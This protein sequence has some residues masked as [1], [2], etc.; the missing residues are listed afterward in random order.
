[1]RIFFLVLSFFIFAHSV[2]AGTANLSWNANTE[3]DLAGYKIYYGASPR[4][5]TCP[6]GGYSSNI[7]VG[8]V[9][10]YALSGL[11]DGSTYYFS[12]TA[13]DTSNNESC[14]SGEVSK[15]ISVPTSV[16]IYLEAESA[17]LTSPMQILNSSSAS[18][19]AYISVPNAA[20]T[21][22]K[23]ILNFNLTQAGDYAI[24]GRVIAPTSSDDS[25]HI[26]IDADTID[27]SAVD[28]VSTIWDVQQGTS[29]VWDRVS[30]RVNDTTFANTNRI[31]TLSSGSHVL[32]INRREDGTQ[33]DR[34]FITNNLSATPSEAVSIT[35]V[36]FT[37]ELES[38][39]IVTGR[40]F[41]I[42][43]FN[44]GTSVQAAQF[45]AQ[46]DSSNNILMPETISLN[47]GNYDILTSTNSYLK[48]KKAGVSL[49]S[50]STIILPT[51][52][53]GDLNNDNSINSLDW[54][55]MSPKWN[56]NDVISDINKDGLVNSID[57][58]FM[59]NNWGKAGD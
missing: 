46:P 57:F 31:F 34:I 17:T 27:N 1:M 6:P 49:N 38:T 51:L 59:N 3:S 56:T 52:L 15:F 53:S 11:T 23:A 41:T 50:N 2:L 58:S 42:T 22:G 12:I 47:L 35:N 54:S 19:G 36:K 28:A 14:F 30:M 55:V 21:G 43:I 24:W 45:T 32:Y 44:T 40:D 25:F 20:G 13:Y 5:S 9:T 48:K 10:S 8:N 39:S 26:S 33:L 7:S 29:W 37:P 18:G 16:N 4:T